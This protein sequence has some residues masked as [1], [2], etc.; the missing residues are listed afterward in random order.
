MNP[1]QASVIF[2]VTT[3]LV[4][5]AWAVIA[6]W[7]SPYTPWQ[8]F[9]YFLNVLLTRILWRA[10]VPRRLPVAP[11][12]GAVVIANHRS[13]VDPCFIQL[14]AGRVV[15][16]MV[17]KEYFAV[18]VA[19]TFLRTTQAIPTRRG[20]QDTAATRAAIRY[21][22][23][24]DLVGILPEGRINTTDRLLLPARPGAAMIA[25]AARVPIVPCY[26]EGSPVGGNVW[27]PLWTPARVR[28]VFGT[29]IQSDPD[30]GQKRPSGAARQLTLRCMAEIARLAGQEDFPIQ[31]AGRRWLP[32][33]EDG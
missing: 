5:C 12:Q 11:G 20:G 31:L 4:P 8:S 21:A 15:H 16:W 13:S 9:V 24:G 26:I 23:Q 14:A 19:G 28:V 2:L 7:Q 10:R 17:A 1:D 32:R 27:S 6:L 22:S 33:D 25:L 29:P 30:P 3:A 18:P